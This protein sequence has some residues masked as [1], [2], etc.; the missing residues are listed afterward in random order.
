ML[1]GSLLLG[2]TLALT[3]RESL[4]AW[5]LLGGVLAGCAM[6]GNLVVNVTLS[7]WFVERRGI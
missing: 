6:L 4:G 1:F 3:S 2:L 5:L 7:K